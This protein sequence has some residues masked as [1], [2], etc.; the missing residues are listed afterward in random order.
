MCPGKGKAQALHQHVRTPSGVARTPQMKYGPPR[1]GLDLH[2][3][4]IDPIIGV[5]DIPV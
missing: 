5:L 2:V 1:A 4:Y 3:S